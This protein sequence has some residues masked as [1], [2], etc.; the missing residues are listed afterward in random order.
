MCACLRITDSYNNNNN[1]KE[2]LKT[3]T[4]ESMVKGLK[5]IPLI[6][7]L[8]LFRCSDS[9]DIPVRCS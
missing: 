9:D 6:W 3:Y 4:H 5:L 7:F 1:K 2:R 8:S